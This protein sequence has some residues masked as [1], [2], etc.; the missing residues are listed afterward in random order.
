M[1]VSGS[2]VDTHQTVASIYL[3]QS[4]FIPSVIMPVVMIVSGTEDGVF[5]VATGDDV[6]Q[7]IDDL[8]A[9]QFVEQALRHDRCGR[10]SV[11]TWRAPPP[12]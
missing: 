9:G 10:Q 3:P 12:G 6:G 2:R 7:Q 4:E 11:P 1:S 8:F 5:R